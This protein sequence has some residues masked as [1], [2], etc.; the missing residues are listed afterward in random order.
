MLRSV[1]TL[2]SQQV[3]CISLH[4]LALTEAACVV[5]QFYLTDETTKNDP[6]DILQL[7]W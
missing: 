2:N 7:F 1:E 6:F 5:Y 3:A 4:F